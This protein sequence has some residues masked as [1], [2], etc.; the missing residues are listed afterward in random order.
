MLLKI[1]T[2]GHKHPSFSLFIIEQDTIGEN[3][4]KTSGIQ[5]RNLALPSPIDCDGV[6]LH[7]Y[8]TTLPVY[9]YTRPTTRTRIKNAYVQIIIY[10]HR[11]CGREQKS[12]GGNTSSNPQVLALVPRPAIKRTEKMCQHHENNQTPILLLEYYLLSIIKNP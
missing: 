9:V 3:K 8:C 4:K 11:N 2:N 7:Q 5:H 12:S 10:Q 1:N 6:Q